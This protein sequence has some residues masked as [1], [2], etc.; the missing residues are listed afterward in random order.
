MVTLQQVEELR[1][2]A[3]ITFNEAKEALEETNGDI[4]EAIINLEK[5]GRIEPPK[6]GGYYST[7]DSGE[8]GEQKSSEAKA[9]TESTQK[10]SS[11][12]SDLVNRF[13]TFMGKLFHKGNRNIFEVS[14][15]GQSTMTLP[16]TVL[17]IL[18]LFTF[19]ITV[20]LMIIGLFFGYK[21]SFSGPELGKEEVNRTMDQ[22][23]DVVGN[24]KKEFSGENKND[25]N[26][27]S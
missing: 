27:N 16:V 3:D 7:K 18:L 24:L 20:P 6:G 21:Y 10:T 1:R 17:V 9:G 12:F 4:L 26:T 15:N 8:T 11:S 23:S 5:N 2:Y 25:K 22:V 14:K 13:T 19:W